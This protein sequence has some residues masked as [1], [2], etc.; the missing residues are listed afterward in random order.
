MVAFLR[1]SLVDVGGFGSS[2]VGLYNVECVE[3]IDLFPE[4]GRHKFKY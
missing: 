4:C 1:D 3:F 2:H